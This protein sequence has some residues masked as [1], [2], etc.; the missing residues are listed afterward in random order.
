MDCF[1]VGKFVSTHGLK[2]EIKIISQV[3]NCDSLF[4]IG[5]YIY[6][7]DEKL[8]FIIKTYR[9]HQKY[10]MLTLESLDNIEKVLPYK[11][12]NLYVDKNDVDNDLIENVLGYDVYNNDIH[13]GKVIELL[14]GVKYDFIV[15]GDSRI[16]IPFI[17][18]FIINIDK[19][20]Q[21]IKSNYNI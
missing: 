12:L 11:G 10:H 20:K 8:S 5:N 19:D 1:C 15:V 14:K 6:I 17:D 4:K 3:S 9:K 13:I 2:G 16:I 21:I 7:G 18:V